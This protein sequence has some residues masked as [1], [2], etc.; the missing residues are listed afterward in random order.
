MWGAS[1]PEMDQPKTGIDAFLVPY[2]NKVSVL[3][4]GLQVWTKKIF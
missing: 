4:K 3:E 2:A 1:L